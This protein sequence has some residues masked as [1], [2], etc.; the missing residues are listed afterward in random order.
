MRDHASGERPFRRIASGGLGA[1]PIAPKL[2]REI[3]LDWAWLDVAG[4]AVAR[5]APVRRVE[6]GVLEIEAAD[7]S[8]EGAL[9]R[10]MPQLAAKL[11]AAHPHL[12]VRRFRIRGD[13]EST[14]IDGAA[15]VAAEPARPPRR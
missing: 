10:L 14:E 4:E 12:R 2:K 15:S 8:W 13:A 11:A 7:A 6:R 5:R 1:L 9:R 3:E